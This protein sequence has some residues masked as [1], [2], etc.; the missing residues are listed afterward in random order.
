[1]RRR[2]D[3]SRSGAKLLTKDEARRIAVNI[4]TLPGAAQTLTMFFNASDTNS[5][6]GFCR[7]SGRVPCATNVLAITRQGRRVAQAAFESCASLARRDFVTFISSMSLNAELVACRTSTPWKS[8]QHKRRFRRSY[9]QARRQAT[10][11]RAVMDKAAWAGLV[12]TD[13]R[14]VNSA[15]VILAEHG[16]VP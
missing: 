3:Q 13:C 4:A 12:R 1:M 7:L 6:I 10:A 2:F 11:G 15:L 5:P 8:R 9:R 16:A 14:V